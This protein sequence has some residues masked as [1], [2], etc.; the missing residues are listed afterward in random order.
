MAE[1]IATPPLERAPLEL[2]GVRLSAPATGAITALAP[3]NGQ[4]AALS[5]ALDAAL[6]LRF[7]APG[8]VY[9]AGDA[10]AVWSGR[11]QAFVIGAAVP[12]LGGLAAVTDQSDAWACLR[13]EGPGSEAVLA[14]LVPLDLRAASFAPGRAARSGLNHI[15]ALIWRDEAG[16]SI[17]VMRS[18]AQSAWH[19]VETAMRGLAARG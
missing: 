5:K 10:L 17:L 9:A 4:E 11:G 18:F 7:P 13:L 1:L 8:E 6:G 15:M 2:G 12:A 19:E 3:F 16:F 14:R